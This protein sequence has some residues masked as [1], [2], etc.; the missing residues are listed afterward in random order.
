MSQDTS[1][2]SAAL[3]AALIMI[4]VFVALV[5]VPMLVQWLA[6]YNEWLA[7]SVGALTILAFFAVFWLRARYQRKRDG[8]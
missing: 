4:A 6:Q 2:R 1:P 5:F 3:A 7:Y 8:E